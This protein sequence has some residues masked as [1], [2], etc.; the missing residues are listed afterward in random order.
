MKRERLRQ[1]TDTQTERNREIDLTEHPKFLVNKPSSLR[2][3][4]RGAKKD[5]WEKTVNVSMRR[6]RRSEG[7]MFLAK[8]RRN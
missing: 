1:K 7:K 6:W 3:S 5:P 8:G 4:E 2:R